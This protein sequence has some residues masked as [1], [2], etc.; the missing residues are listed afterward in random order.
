MSRKILTALALTVGAV[1]WMPSAHATLTITVFDN[2]VA[3]AATS[4]V[5]GPGTLTWI[6][7]TGCADTAF[8]SISITENGL[9]GSNPD[10]ATTTIDATTTGAFSGTHVLM[11][12]AVQT[13]LTFPGG[14]SDTT[15]TF[16]ALLGSPGPA[17]E[18][19][20][21]NAQVS[22]T[23]APCTSPLVSRSG[24]TP[25]DDFGAIPNAVPAI[26]QDEEQFF[27]TFSAANQTFEGTMAFHA[28][29]TIPEPASLA[30]LG[31]ALV[32]FGWLGRR[33]K[34]S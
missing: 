5:P 2:G 16:N 25:V 3:V 34:A 10:L 29:P 28:T 27:I 24:S 17:T 30:L 8:S 4:I 15:G 19:M 22:T 13:G 12:D 20:C 23:A 9:G 21:I 26:T 32:G 14:N 6:C 1:A 7:G 18:N 31:S 11:I 33:R